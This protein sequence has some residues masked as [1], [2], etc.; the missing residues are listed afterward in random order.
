MM[1][2]PRNAVEVVTTTKEMLIPQSLPFSTPDGLR[3][4]KGSDVKRKVQEC[5][6]SMATPPG[7]TNPEEFI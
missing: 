7:V 4:T 2:S 5:R 6:A 1:Q 3:Q